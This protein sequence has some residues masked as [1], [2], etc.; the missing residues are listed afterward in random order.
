MKVLQISN[1]ECTYIGENR[2][3]PI[4]PQTGSLFPKTER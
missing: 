1:M 4:S 3:R 2:L